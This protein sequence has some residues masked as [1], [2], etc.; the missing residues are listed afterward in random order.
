MKT[1]TKCQGT[2]KASRR[3]QKCPKCNGNGLGGL[4]GL[5]NCDL[6]GG[7]GELRERD[8]SWIRIF[9]NPSDKC[10]ACGGKGYI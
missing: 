5:G 10:S 8:D 7:S 6:C 4:F 3:G 1:C 2:G 9:T